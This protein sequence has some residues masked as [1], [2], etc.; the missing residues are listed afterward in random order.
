MS[1]P[2]LLIVA[3]GLISIPAQQESE[4]SYQLH[5]SLTP[6][7]ASLEK[8][9]AS[10]Y[11]SEPKMPLEWFVSLTGRSL[12]GLVS[13]LLSEASPDQYSQLW[14]ASPFHARLN[15]DRLQVMPDTY[16][17]WSES[18]ADWLCDLLNPLLDEEGM[19]LVAS[20]PLL[21]LLCETSIEAA[22]LSFAAV[23]GHTLPNR[24]PEGADGGRLMRL[25]SEIQMMLNQHPSN[26]RWERGEPDVDG[27]WLWGGSPLEGDGQR[28]T[29]AVATRNPML[30]AVTGG[31]DAEV[32]ITEADRLD[33]LVKEGSLLPKRIVLAGNG[34]AVLLKRRIIPSIGRQTWV[35]KGIQQESDLIQALRGMI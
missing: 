18:D 28:G 11:A 30:R 6:F 2:K 25:K 35:P 3:D 29:L 8:M 19:K 33:E 7:R 17:P 32:M 27:L 4:I 21:F 1:E 22:P 16:F 24:H 15:R 13:P 20:G 31:V 10:W 9:S 14:I 5:P 12:S 34:H 26:A 23:S